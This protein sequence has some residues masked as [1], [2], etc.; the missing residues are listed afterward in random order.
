LWG[1]KNGAKKIFAP[2]IFSSEGAWEISQLRSGWFEIKNDFVP[3][4]TV[5][6]VGYFPS[7]LSGRITFD[8]FSSHFVAG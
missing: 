7:S 8:G 6:M 1:T 2:F 3:Q 5:E 4:G